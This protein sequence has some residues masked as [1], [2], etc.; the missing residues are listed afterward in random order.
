[1]ESLINLAV[2]VNQVTIIHRQY[3]IDTQVYVN[4]CLTV[5]VLQERDLDRRHVTQSALLRNLLNYLTT[6]PDELVLVVRH[7]VV[8]DDN[9]IDITSLACPEAVHG[10]TG[11]TDSDLS[12]K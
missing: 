2:S 7:P 10:A 6:L 3:I 1:M 5:L 9:Y 11:P 12:V 8:E 4:T